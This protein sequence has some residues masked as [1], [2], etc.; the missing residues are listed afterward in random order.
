V[1]RGWGDGC[2]RRM[3][4]GRRDRGRFSPAWPGGP[5]TPGHGRVRRTSANRTRRTPARGSERREG[6]EL[7]RL[8][9]RLIHAGRS[10]ARKQFWSQGA[11]LQRSLALARWRSG[12]TSWVGFARFT[13]MVLAPVGTPGPMRTMRAHGMG[14]PSDSHVS[15]MRPCRYS[16]SYHSVLESR[17]MQG[18]IDLV[19]DACQ[20]GPAVVRS[21]S[22][23]AVSKKKSRQI[24]RCCQHPMIPP[25]ADARSATIKVIH[26]Q[27][28]STRRRLGSWPLV[29]RISESECRAVRRRSGDRSRSPCW[30]VHTRHRSYLRRLARLVGRVAFV[31]LSP[32][33]IGNVSQ[34][35]LDKLSCNG[36]E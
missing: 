29:D 7:H 3:R 25:P 36:A 20:R 4:A 5:G 26:V 22:G 31:K 27:T 17:P 18:G 12:P 13:L 33:A 2:G 30:M 10:Q 32:D 14:T 35:E 23:V 8:R 11:P 28:G 15:G 24:S 1:R 6:D 9:E 16:A 19:E 34:N 21:L